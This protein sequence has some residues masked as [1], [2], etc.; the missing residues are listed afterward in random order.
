MILLFGSFCPNVNGQTILPQLDQ[1]LGQIGSTVYQYALIAVGLGF[2]VAVAGWAW[3]SASNNVIWG[4]RS[5][6]TALTAGASAI[7][8]G[9]APSIVNKLM[10]AGQGLGC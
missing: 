7:V 9:A 3:S 4:Q 2:I 10:G 1:L 6:W 5:K 8:L